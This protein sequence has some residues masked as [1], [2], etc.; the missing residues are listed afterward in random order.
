[1]QKELIAGCVADGMVEELDCA[2][3]APK[4]LEE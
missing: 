1:V 4:L 3:D 2:A